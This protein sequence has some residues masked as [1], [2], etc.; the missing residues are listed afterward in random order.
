MNGPVLYAS[1]STS[2]NP[3]CSGVAEPRPFLIRRKTFS[4]LKKR[5]LGEKREMAKKTIDVIK[6]P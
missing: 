3:M 1:I 6:I 5:R 4:D 2:F